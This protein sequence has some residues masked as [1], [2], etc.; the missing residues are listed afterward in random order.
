MQLANDRDKAMRIAKRAPLAPNIA[1]AKALRNESKLAF[2]RVREEYIKNQLD[3][4]KN[5]PKKFWSELENIIPGK[6]NSSSNILNL[7]NDN[8]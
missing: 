6:K 2:K 5:G 8:N 1:P 3:E 7:L 4:H